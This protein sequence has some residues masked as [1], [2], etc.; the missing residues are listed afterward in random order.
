MY[1]KGHLG[2]ALLFA[3]PLMW[4]VGA[5][6][7]NF[8]GAILLSLG[9]V[10]AT[11]V[12][13]LDRYVPWIRHRGVTHTVLFALIVS[14]GG[15]IALTVTLW[16]LGGSFISVLITPQ[17]L[18]VCLGFGILAGLVSHLCIDALAVRHTS[19]VIRP[20]WPVS[21]RPIRLRLTQADSQVSNAGLL[22]GGMVAQL[23]HF[24][25]LVPT[26]IT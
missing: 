18:F 2:A 22:I 14:S 11:S 1:R 3:A 19:R 16:Q 12:P 13:D 5:T 23:A 26:G 4:L 24:L 20:L 7:D 17:Q 21:S 6:T 25:W 9:A 8:F 10:C 15:A